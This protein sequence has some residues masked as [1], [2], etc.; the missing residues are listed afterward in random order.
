MLLP[1]ISHASTYVHKQ[2]DLKQ[3][4]DTLYF[5]AEGLLHFPLSIKSLSLHD[6]LD[7]DGIFHTESILHCYNEILAVRKINSSFLS[8]NLFTPM[9]LI[10]NANKVVVQD[11]VNDMLAQYNMTTGPRRTLH[12][13]SKITCSWRSPDVLV[14]EASCESLISTSATTHDVENEVGQL[15]SIGH[16]P[17]FL[18]VN[19]EKLKVYE[20][21]DELV[22]SD[23]RSRVTWQSLYFEFDTLYL[24]LE[25]ICRMF[26]LDCPFLDCGMDLAS[27]DLRELRDFAKC[28]MKA[29]N[30]EED[31]AGK[32]R[33]KRD[34][35]NTLL[36]GL[37]LVK[38]P[39]EISLE[40]FNKVAEGNFNR[41]RKNQLK[42]EEAFI[43]HSEQLHKTLQAEALDIGNTYDRVST[44]QSHLSFLSKFSHNMEAHLSAH[45]AFAG[46]LSRLSS[47]AEAFMQLALAPMKDEAGSYCKGTDCID[48]NSLVLNK[49]GKSISVSARLLQLTVKEAGRI[50]CKLMNSSSQVFIHGLSDQQV[51]MNKGGYQLRKNNLEVTNGCLRSGENCP[52][53]NRKVKSRDLMLDNFYFSLEKSNVL[54]QC[55]NETKLVTTRGNVTC[56]LE[57]QPIEPP[58][59]ALGKVK[60]SLI[61]PHNIHYYIT[62]PR[63]TKYQ[64]QDE[65]YAIENNP[66]TTHYSWSDFHR[67]LTTKPFHP[68]LHMPHGVVLF[69]PLFFIVLSIFLCCIFKKC[70]ACPQLC[71]DFFKMCI[72][73]IIWCFSGIRKMFVTTSDV[74]NNN[75]ALNAGNFPSAPSCEASTTS[76][77]QPPANASFMDQ[78]G[79]TSSVY[80]NVHPRPPFIEAKGE[81]FCSTSFA[82][83]DPNQIHARDI[84]ELQ[85]Q[86]SEAQRAA[87]RYGRHSHSKK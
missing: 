16:F 53:P 83:P 52:I 72:N 23:T 85:K 48:K 42:L 63:E 15:K 61:Q 29:V 44:L 74:N 19:K 64:T 18:I 21:G 73:A 27:K 57:A 40:N 26:T 81:D 11:T 60:H 7:M 12:T 56:N 78:G 5:F 79:A 51:I 58:F 67:D 65:V 1:T 30:I 10:I 4:E 34:I 17:A 77:T 49:E 36:A 46:V 13:D 47:K 39:G 43:K 32:K 2:V 35:L 14:G 68:F 55:I 20:Q 9:P 84:Q 22:C 75:I 33:K 37:G 3:F 87:D 80:P 82:V 28:L 66:P 76:T 70:P 86:L 8:K 69:T 71:C 24:K 38:S 41:L 59:I 31:V 25:S 45:S 62:I 54:V 50:N 6:N